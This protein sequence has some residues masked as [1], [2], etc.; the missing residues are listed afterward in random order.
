MM[1]YNIS[2]DTKYVNNGER[3]CQAEL[4][5]MQPVNMREIIERPE[6]KTARDGGFGST[7][8]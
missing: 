1:V 2:G 3:I 7:G 8:K 4:V 6:R 5:K